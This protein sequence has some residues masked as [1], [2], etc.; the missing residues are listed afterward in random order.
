MIIVF[1]GQVL[2]RFTFCAITSTVSRVRKYVLEYDYRLYGL[3][4][5]YTRYIYTSLS[6]PL[7]YFSLVGRG[8]GEGEV[9]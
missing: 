8:W 9:W 4:E 7:V 5:S 2:L 3:G 1:R 6:P